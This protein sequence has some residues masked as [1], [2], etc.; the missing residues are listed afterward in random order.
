MSYMSLK[1]KKLDQR[2]TEMFISEFEEGE[3]LC[4]EC[5]IQN[6]Q[7]PPCENAKKAS[8]KRFP[9][10]FEMSDSNP[11]FSCLLVSLFVSREGLDFFTFERK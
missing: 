8:F 9:E 10:L 2:G 3:S 5:N 11:N 1:T 4:L 6:I 7:K